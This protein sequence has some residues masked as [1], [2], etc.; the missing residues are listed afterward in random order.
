MQAHNCGICGHDKHVDLHSA[1]F[2]VAGSVCST[3]GDRGNVS[4]TWRL[5]QS[6][7]AG[8]NCYTHR[9]E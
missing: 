9:T 5:V 7:F 3:E 1:V 4:Q 2:V 8:D 6:C